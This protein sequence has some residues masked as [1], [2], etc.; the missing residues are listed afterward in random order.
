MVQEGF[1][2][3]QLYKVPKG[4]HG[5]WV[6]ITFD[7]KGRLIASDQG[8]KGLYRITPPVVG[9]DEVTKIEKLK[10]PYSSAQGLLYAFDSLYVSINGGI[11][12][13]LNRAQDTTGDD[14]FDTFSKLKE[15]R[16]G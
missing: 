16:V 1:Q 2:I 15:F 3:E 6:A 4:D 13:G 7:N 12:S 5:S 8:N 14:Q 9:S 10:T 11:G